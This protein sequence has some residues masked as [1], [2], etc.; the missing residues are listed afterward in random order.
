MVRLGPLSIVGRTPMFSIPI[1]VFLSN[2]T[3]TA[4]TPSAGISL[5]GS[6]TLKLALENLFSGLPDSRLLL[7]RPGSIHI[8]GNRQ[9]SPLLLD[10]EVCGS[11]KSL[12]ERW[13]CSLFLYCWYMLCADH[14]YTNFFPVAYI[15][16][17]TFA[18]VVSE[19]MVIADNQ[20]FYLVTFF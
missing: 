17:E 20:V 9:P 7:F 15:I 5:S 1:Y 13:V 8:S 19:T 4:Y 16:F 3:H 6:S 14:F 11:G 18:A 10:E 2:V 12:P